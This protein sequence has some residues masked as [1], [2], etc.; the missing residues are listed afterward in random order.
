MWT[1]YK[2]EHH[3]TLKRKEF[4]SFVTTWI[5]LETIILSEISQAERDTHMAGYCLYVD[6]KKVEFKETEGSGQGWGNW[7]D[8]GQRIQKFIREKEKVQMIYCITR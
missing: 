1:I 6:S 3:L 5:N 8:A 7:G 4:L 2:I